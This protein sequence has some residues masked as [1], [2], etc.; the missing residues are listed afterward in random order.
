MNGITDSNL[1]LKKLLKDL[2]K[3]L[4]VELLKIKQ[5][6]ENKTKTIIDGRNAG[7][8]IKINAENV[9]IKKLTIQHSGIYYP[10]SGIN[11]ST[12]YATI[13]N[14]ILKNNFYGIILH[15]AQHNT[16]KN[17]T[18]KDNNNCGIYLGHSS[19]NNMLN[20][21]VTNH[22]YSGFGIYYEVVV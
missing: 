15:N 22:T 3:F 17:N 9:I 12:S 2:N 5:I 21:I 6:V 11:L 16:I 18:I 20:N 10:N 1:S 13:G 4:K 7:N 19:N 14:T 8:V